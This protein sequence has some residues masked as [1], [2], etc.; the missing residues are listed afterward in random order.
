MGLFAL[1]HSTHRQ[2]CDEFS[3]VLQSMMIENQVTEH[4]G[5]YYLLVD[6]LL[7]NKAYTQL[8]LYVDENAPQEVI[9]KTVIGFF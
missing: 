3:L 4:E 8:K 2:K 9:T 5:R 1:F 7:A 6:E